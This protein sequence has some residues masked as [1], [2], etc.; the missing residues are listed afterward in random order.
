MVLHAVR[1]EIRRPPGFTAIALRFC[2]LALLVLSSFAPAQAGSSVHSL[3]APGAERQIVV[4]TMSAAQVCHHDVAVHVGSDA[5]VFHAG[6]LTALPVRG[7]AVTAHFSRMPRPAISPTAYVGCT[8][9][10]DTPPPIAC[11]AV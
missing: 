4:A 8:P 5:C 7:S 9:A 6:C 10:P 3:G 2:A 11:S 1:G